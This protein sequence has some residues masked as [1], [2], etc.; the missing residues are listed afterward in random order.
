MEL[1]FLSIGLLGGWRQWRRDRRGAC[2]M[3]TLVAT[4]SIVLVFYLNFKYG[5][6]IYPDKRDLLR[7]VRERD[8]FFI[9]S[10]LIWGVWVA[11]GLGVL[12]EW[13]AD[14]FAD[15]LDETGRWRMALPTIIVATI[16]FF[17]NRLTASRAGETLPRDFAVD[18]L[19]SVEPYAVLITA[20]DNDTFP[21]WYA[22]EVEG[23]R[24]DVLLA[25]QSLMNTDWHLRQLRRRAI[26]PF[27][28]A[29]A[30][31]PY[32]GRS[33][34]MPATP[35]LSLSDQEIDALPPG[36]Q[37]TQPSQFQVGKVRARLSPGVLDTAI[38]MGIVT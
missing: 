26:V 5:F 33:W 34:P 14:F 16:P 19:E 22:Q 23:V 7:E 11:L 35:G 30:A 9:A 31:A 29:H 13:V 1:A 8:Y 4:L 17:G 12:M 24:R 20:G 2:A 15:R 21:L 6:S 18:L 36:Y 38:S 10:F 37:L 28:S 3:T 32:R 25:N 27:D